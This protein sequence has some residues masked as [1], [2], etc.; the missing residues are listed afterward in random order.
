MSAT[1]EVLKFE[2]KI[3]DT[4]YQLAD[5][6]QKL[7]VESEQISITS[8]QEYDLVA[9]DLKII[10]NKEREIE[11]MRKML[12]APILAAG[13]AIDSFFAKPLDNLARAKSLR[14]KVILEYQ[15]EKRRNAMAE[16]ARLR[17]LQREEQERLAREAEA[18]EKAGNKEA[19]N[20]VIEQAATMPEVMVQKEATK[21][22]GVKT[23]T[24]WG[25][26]LISKADVIKAVAAGQIPDIALEVN[27]KFFNQQAVSL[28]EAFNYP[29]VK[30]V[31]K[32]TIAA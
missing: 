7:L 11:D 26:E 10:A 30:A 6:S 16:E 14:K 28:K 12:K 17:K 27:M 1:A 9:G 22:E 19:A 21:V 13:K 18:L 5:D 24:R 32:T 3:P 15:D 20:A 4:A 29:G 8:D 2:Q 25:A 23:Q 31:P